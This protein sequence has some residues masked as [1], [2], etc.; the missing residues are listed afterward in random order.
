MDLTRRH[1]CARNTTH[2][3][4]TNQQTHRPQWP[5][6][7]PARKDQTRTVSLGHFFHGMDCVAHVV[8]VCVVAPCK[9]VRFGCVYG[10]QTA[11]TTLVPSLCLPVGAVQGF[12]VV[13]QNQYLVVIR[14]GAK[15]IAPER[16][17]RDCCWYTL[18]CHRAQRM[19]MSEPPLA[20][21]G[22]AT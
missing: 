18:L 21:H 2:M 17:F 5:E 12:V 9:R 7:S 13:A 10:C 11:A 14:N 15:S 3:V 16:C 19:G 8:C 4:R 22:M 6:L 1:H 20:S